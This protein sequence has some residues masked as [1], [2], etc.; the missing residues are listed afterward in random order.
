MNKEK[1][2]S[3]E[4]DFRSIRELV[5]QWDIL[6]LIKTGSPKDEYDNLTFK[7]LSG[8]KNGKS[9]DELKEDLISL[10]GDDFGFQY[11]TADSNNRTRLEKE[12]E[13]LIEKGKKRPANN[14]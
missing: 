6:D 4:T 2:L 7:I 10:L 3:W 11:Q 9:D 1:N 14:I 8:L 5:N 12:I 13:Q